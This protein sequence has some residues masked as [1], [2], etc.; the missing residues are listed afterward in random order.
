MYKITE[1]SEDAL[2]RYFSILSKFG[3]RSYSDVYR[4][5]SLI[6]IEELLTGNLKEFLVEEDYRNIDKA[7]Y[8]LIS[9]TCFI[10]FP[11]YSEC[12]DSTE[13]L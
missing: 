11:K 6:F 2:I 8:C 9:N 13:G 4:L 7:L 10:D 12:E 3:Y 5:L 1:M